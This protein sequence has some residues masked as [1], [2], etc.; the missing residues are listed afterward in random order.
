[1]SY[2][3]D[4]TV[5]LEACHKESQADYVHQ[6]L[7]DFSNYCRQPN[8]SHHNMQ[9]TE[10]ESQIIIDYLI[11]HD[12]S[13]EL[14]LSISNVIQKTKKTVI[15]DFFVA[16]K[17]QMDV[18]FSEYEINSSLHDYPSKYTRISLSKPK[19][20]VEIALENEDTFANSFVIGITIKDGIR[21][22][23]KTKTTI[24]NTT[25][26]NHSQSG[27]FNEH[28]LYWD[29]LKTYGSWTSDHTLII[30][31]KNRQFVIDHI[32]NEL[33]QLENIIKKHPEVLIP[34]QPA[35]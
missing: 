1:M 9:N 29:W 22:N 16:L 13:F 26:K 3:G 12:K 6:F 30:I 15:S 21:L 14:A 11:E 32:I 20:G 28:W 33:K 25:K 4:I 7:L 10:I 8:L 31:N 5:W 24:F 17:N 2:K 34:C 18:T 19:W 23:T 27:Q 35:G